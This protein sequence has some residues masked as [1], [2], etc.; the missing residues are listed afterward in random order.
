M[1][2]RP[3][4]P[5]SLETK[6]EIVEH[7]NEILHIDVVRKIGHN[8]IVKVTTPVLITWNDGK[9]R[10]CG[11][12][13]ALNNY[14]KAGRKLKDSEA[15]YGATQTEFLFLFWA[16]EKIHYYLECSVFEVY[17]D[18]TALKSLLHMNTTNRHI[19][20]WQIAIQ[21]YLG[22]MNIIYKEGKSHTNADGLSRWSLENFKSNTA[23]DAELKARFPSI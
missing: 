18:C 15:R 4:Y 10:L 14:T 1:L 2:K 17:T 16:L 3:P 6:K 5:A 23:Y 13:R 12:F 11:D 19:L 7:I 8:E 20:R 21:A 22:N 9:S